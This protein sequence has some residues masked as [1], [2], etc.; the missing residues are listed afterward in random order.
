MQSCIKT[1]TS[2]F[3]GRRLIQVILSLTGYPESNK[4]SLHKTNPQLFFLFI[5]YLNPVNLNSNGYR[6]Y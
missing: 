1:V 2:R 3:R 4:D 5:P 6:H